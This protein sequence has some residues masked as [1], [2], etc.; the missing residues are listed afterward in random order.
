MLEMA[1][2]NGHKDG[3]IVLEQN[4]IN[5]VVFEHAGLVPIG[6]LVDVCEEVVKVVLEGSKMNDVTLRCDF[7]VRLL[8]KQ[9]QIHELFLL[10]CQ[11]F[12]GQSG[13]WIFVGAVGFT[14]QNLKKY[15]LMRPV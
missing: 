5:A 7:L 14:H 15:E 10:R 6:A 11:G 2:S 9:S 12:E 4:R 1:A 8:P 13:P 3:Q